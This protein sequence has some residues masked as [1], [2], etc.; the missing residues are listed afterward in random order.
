MNRQY[1]VARY[2]QIVEQAETLMP[3]ISLTTDIIVG[4]PGETEADF[5][6]TLRVV[7]AVGYDSAY[8]F[9]YSPRY[10]TPAAAAQ[11]QIPQEVVTERFQ[12]LLEL[13]NRNSLAANQRRMG[14]TYEVLIEGRS[15]HRAE[16]LTGRASDNH[17]INFTVPSDLFT[18]QG[19]PE[20]DFAAL[21]EQLEGRFA[22]VHITGARPFSLEGKLLAML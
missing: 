20:G 5:T 13:Q 16:Q 2:M 7:E 10:G 3:D 4:F 21:G 15:D 22:K 11:D 14:R 12:R 18:R 19:L 17:L 1:D 9:Q 6:E 8:T